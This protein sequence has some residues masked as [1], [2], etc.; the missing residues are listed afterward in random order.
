MLFS[1]SFRLFCYGNKWKPSS[2]PFSL[3]LQQKYV[4][5]ERSGCIKGDTRPFFEKTDEVVEY[6]APDWVPKLP[7]DD[8]EFGRTICSVNLQ[9]WLETPIHTTICGTVRKPEMHCS[10]WFS[11]TRIK[12][13]GAIPKLLLHFSIRAATQWQKK[14][15][16]RSFFFVSSSGFA[17]VRG[18]CRRGQWSFR[19]TGHEPA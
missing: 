10:W 3:S 12:N 6:H 2:T 13:A 7:E 1:I 14:N 16:P 8:L 17:R 5:I 19:W 15:D 11:Y 9:W 4:H 18:F